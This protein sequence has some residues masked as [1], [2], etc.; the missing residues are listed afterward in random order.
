[1]RPRTD[2]SHDSHG[3]SQKRAVSYREAP[4]RLEPSPATSEIHHEHHGASRTP[5]RGRRCRLPITHRS[6]DVRP[7][8]SPP[9]VPRPIPSRLLIPMGRIL[10]ALAT[11]DVLSGP[12]EEMAT[13]VALAPAALAPAALPARPR[14]LGG[15]GCVVHTGP[16]WR[17]TV[18]FERRSLG[19]RR[20]AVERRRP[21]RAPA[22]T[23]A[24]GS[25][26]RD[27]ESG[28]THAGES[29]A[30]VHLAFNFC[31]RMCS[32]MTVPVAARRE[33]AGPEEIRGARNERRRTA[34][35]L[36]R[37]PSRSRRND[38]Q[39]STQ[40]VSLGCP[41]GCSIPRWRG[42]ATLPDWRPS[43]QSLGLSGTWSR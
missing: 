43:R 17:L 27:R 33:R 32:T 31:R 28:C 2:H 5:G 11:G 25:S 6:P 14:H 22:K 12:L 3:G 21:M 37:Y 9:G 7:M 41:A 42:S 24:T 30:E 8:I 15:A 34:Q 29:S 18:R 16:G 10:E 20:V 38:G 35:V 13:R 40:P 39:A 1:M 36:S 26:G 4:V 19:P 23:P